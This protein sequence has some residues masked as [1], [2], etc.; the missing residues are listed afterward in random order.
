MIRRVLNELPQQKRF[1]G[2][3]RLLFRK[4]LVIMTCGLMGHNVDNDFGLFRQNGS[5][6]LIEEPGEMRCTE[7][8]SLII[9]VILGH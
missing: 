4:V 7:G 5:L 8:N 1:I 9:K 3:V 2:R 6:G